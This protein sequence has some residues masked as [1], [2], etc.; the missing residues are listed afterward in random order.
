M[1]HD[2]HENELVHVG[3]GGWLDEVFWKHYFSRL[4]KNG[5]KPRVLKYYYVSGDSK[6][7]PKGVK[8]LVVHWNSMLCQVRNTRVIK[9]Q[10]LQ[11]LLDNLRPQLVHT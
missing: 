5:L 2:L 10:E 7:H 3:D 9:E 8:S 1:S 11:K 4:I 6:G